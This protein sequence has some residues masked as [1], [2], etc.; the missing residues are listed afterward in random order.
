MEL[1]NKIKKLDLL[2]ERQK[3]RD[4]EKVCE[5]YLFTYTQREIENLT[6][7][8]SFPRWLQCPGLHWAK[9]RI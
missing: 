2:F 3:E 9:A 6:S 5:I 4:R 7:I 8:D 1:Y